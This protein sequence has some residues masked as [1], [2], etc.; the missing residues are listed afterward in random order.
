[1]PVLAGLAIPKTAP[2]PRGGKQLIEWLTAAR[3][4]RRRSAPRASSPW[5]ARGCRSA[6]SGPASKI[7]C[8]REH[9]ADAKD[10]LTSLL[11]IGLGAKGGDFNKVF[12][13]TP[14]RGS[15]SRARQSEDGPERRGADPAGD[16]GQDR[17]QVLGAG[18][19]EHGSVSGRSCVAGADSEAD[20]GGRERRPSRLTRLTV[21]GSAVLAD[22]PNRRVPGRCSSPGR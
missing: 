15:S 3:R 8:G 17:R 21:G 20:G 4:R 12:T 7:A 16:H 11:P 9:A 19:A 6:R 22:P 10:A 1:M 14:S 13:S 2:N 18:P 5:S